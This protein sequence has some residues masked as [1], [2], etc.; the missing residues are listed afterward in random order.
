MCAHG[1]RDGHPGHG[2]AIRFIEWTYDAD[3]SDSTYT[4]DF[5]YLLRERGEPVRAVHET[6]VFGI[7][8]RG[9]W[10]DLLRSAGFEPAAAADPWGREVF[11]GK[12]L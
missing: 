10:I 8:P 2:R 11:T 1:G 4:V 6:H 12:K 5:V 7:F 9:R 3:P